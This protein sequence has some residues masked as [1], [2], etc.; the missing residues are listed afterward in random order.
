MAPNGP[1]K[2]WLISLSTYLDGECLTPSVEEHLSRCE[3]CRHW[4][5]AVRRDQGL[6]RE[7]FCGGP[8][9]EFVDGVMAE[10]RRIAI[11][12]R[13]SALAPMLRV[14]RRLCWA[15][16]AAVVAVTIL[17]VAVAGPL[18]LRTQANAKKLMCL[19][20]V[21]LVANATRV[22]AT[23]NSDHLPTGA[24]WDT[25]LR[26]YVASEIVFYC[27]ATKGMMYGFPTGL[28]G[29]SLQV[30]VYPSATLALFDQG[31]M[32]G[33]FAP[34]HHGVGSVA[35]L[36]G[37]ATAMPAL[38]ALPGI[39]ADEPRAQPGSAARR[40]ASATRARQ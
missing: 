4:V 35:F 11:R 26:P 6:V 15:E 1:C 19:D 30:M 13:V 10:I 40:D 5:E 29:Q 22:Y 25:A 20:N 8:E 7:A 3:G 33:V 37:H 32:P 2:E 14:R 21:R 18:F 16:M 38:P 27:P 12:D 28:S 39:E 17:L 34:R 9:P 24:R 23:D 36:D 31:P